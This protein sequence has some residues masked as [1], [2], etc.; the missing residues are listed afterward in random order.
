[1]K[2]ITLGGHVSTERMLS[3]IR[4]A[5]SCDSPIIR[6]QILASFESTSLLQLAIL[7]FFYHLSS[8]QQS[9]QLHISAHCDDW[10]LK[11]ARQLGILTHLVIAD[12]WATSSTLL[13]EILANHHLRTLELNCPISDMGSAIAANP[14]LQTL[15]LYTYDDDLGKATA[16]L[17][18]ALSH[19]PTTV[20]RLHLYCTKSATHTIVN[21]GL[22]P[23]LS[24]CQVEDLEITCIRHHQ[25]T[26]P[27]F[28]LAQLQNAMRTNQSLKR[29]GIFHADLTTTQ[30]D[31]DL[32]SH[33]HHHSSITHLDFFGNE[34]ESLY[35]PL[36]L[37]QS[38]SCALQELH[39]QQN[40]CSIRYPRDSYSLYSESP[41]SPTHSPHSPTIR[42][43][44]DD[45]ICFVH[46][47]TKL[48][49]RHPRL[50]LFGIHP[51]SLHHHDRH[52]VYLA[53]A[54]RMSIR[55]PALLQAPPSVWP[56]IM[57]RISQHPTLYM[58]TTSPTGRC[59]SPTSAIISGSTRLLSTKR[60]NQST[61]ER[62]FRHQRQA[63]LIYQLLQNYPSSS[64]IGE[65]GT[66]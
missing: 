40:P 21:E 60:L 11:R 36:F 29:L 31:Q 54:N 47:Y 3:Q 43:T 7:R 53:D 64:W 44:E 8:H 10:I 18:T 48:L 23:L 45:P 58:E 25:H 14:F 16:D 28:P 17:L 42:R 62:D 59:S 32:L 63:T 4:R 35:F 49:Q 24:R 27:R 39:V 46:F 57:E 52:L 26:S 51:R 30:V 13:F 5:H 38:Q 61:R 15:I 56:W 1:M 34:I 55:H 66:T 2:S 12:R 22:T 6:L 20:T 65:L 41:I 9:L 37:N 19:R 50:Y 33:L